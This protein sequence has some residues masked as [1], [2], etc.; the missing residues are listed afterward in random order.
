MRS[1][2][3]ARKALLLGAVLLSLAASP[4]RPD[5]SMSHS[6]ETR[7]LCYCNCDMAKGAPMCHHMCELPKYEHRSW[8]TSCHTPPQADINQSSPAQ[9]P[10]KHTNRIEHS[11]LN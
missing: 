10:S 8:A 6:A 11:K 7:K 1:H 2:R 5:T 9:P 4:A 3:S